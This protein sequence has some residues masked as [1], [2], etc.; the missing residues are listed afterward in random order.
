MRRHR[1]SPASI[2]L[3]AS[4]LLV[5]LCASPIAAAIT[6]PGALAQPIAP[7]E[8]RE[9]V[10]AAIARGQ[11]GDCAGVLR[12]LDPIVPRLG[13]GA[14][15]NGVQ[16]LR[17]ACL[18]SAGRI[19]ELAAVQREL[20]VAMP[21][22]AMVRSFGIFIA[23]DEQRITDAAEQLAVMAEDDPASLELISGQS[24][25]GIAQ[26]LNE[27]AQFALRDRLFV[28]LARADWQPQD[29]PDMRDALAQGAIEALLSRREV[30]EAAELLNRVEMPELLYAM[31]TERVYEPL[32][33]AIEARLGP[34]AAKAVDRFAAARLDDFARTP[35]DRLAAR[36]AIRSFMLLG[37]YTDA[38]EIA[39]RIPVAEGM[40]EDEV[41]AVRYHAQ[42]LA[43]LGRQREA[44]ER[45]RA[46]RT[47][48]LA[49]TPE[50]TSG[51]VS[52]AEM[53]DE[54]GRP[55]EGLAVA[56]DTLARG[57]DALSDWGKAWLRRTEACSLGAL[58]RTAEAKAAGDALKAAAA[59]NQPAAIEALLCLKR[60]DEAAAI[61]VKAFATSEGASMLADQFQPEGA[62]WA[63]A[64]SR[65]RGLWARFL[66]RPDIKAAFERRA[67]ILP[68]PLWPARTP[69]PIPRTSP[70]EPGTLA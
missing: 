44:I 10:R 29:R 56:R 54:A 26:K 12:L 48:D 13:A 66:L 5:A 16:R 17:L 9:V 37:R 19:P 14:E 64:D 39:E 53:L 36:G 11:A 55:E 60:D 45:L 40:G 38:A 32:W 3:V 61:A 23:L 33:P 27:Q 43:A 42:A 49:K 20:A 1:R 68:R 47:L 46:F 35:D 65:L 31:A 63:P 70:A 41:A 30:N 58:G 2:D 8:L 21:R 52:L 25:R 22:D 69:R 34:Q 67:R 6:P 57:D 51:L 50:A 4:G 7:D 62:I 28:A 15:R 24:W 59:R 18:A